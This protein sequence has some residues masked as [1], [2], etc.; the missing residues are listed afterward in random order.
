MAEDLAQ[1]INQ[2]GGD[3]LGFK[4]DVTVQADID[5]LIA[6]ADEFNIVLMY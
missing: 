3:A 2:S 1:S 5:N 6:R 4:L